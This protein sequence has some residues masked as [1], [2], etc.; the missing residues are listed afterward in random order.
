MARVPSKNDFSLPVDGI[1]TFIFARRTMGDQMKIHVEYARATEGVKPTAWLD[2]V[3]TYL[4]TIRTMLV[5]GPQG[6]DLDD[7]DPYDDEA[8]EKLARVYAALE[9][10][11]RSFRQRKVE[12]GKAGGEGTGANP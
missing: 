11:E 9:D 10:K 3:A 12:E 8:L 2:S 7:L 1:G 4:S 6:F 5:L